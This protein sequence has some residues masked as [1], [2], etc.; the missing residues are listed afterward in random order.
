[1][2][3][4]EHAGQQILVLDGPPRLASAGHKPAVFV[5][6]AGKAAAIQVRRHWNAASHTTEVCKCIPYCGSSRIDSF[7]SAVEMVGS[8]M[9]EQVLLVLSE[10]AWHSLVFGLARLRIEE[11]KG[12]RIKLQRHGE[13]CNGRC[14]VE[15]LSVAGNP[16]PPFDIGWAMLKKLGIAAGSFFSEA[17]PSEVDPPS[18]TVS[19]PK[20]RIPLGRPQKR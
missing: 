15:V 5:L 17:N 14:V 18:V 3:M 8:D 1:M 9:W 13:K 6:T 10:Q 19:P 12:A 7:L 16:P 2:P 4:S 20:P 11:V